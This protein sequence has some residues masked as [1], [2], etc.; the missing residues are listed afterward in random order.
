MRENALEAD[1]LKF[2]N[3]KIK[4]SYHENSL[5]NFTVSFNFI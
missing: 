1:T 5:F 3:F 2:C 4:N